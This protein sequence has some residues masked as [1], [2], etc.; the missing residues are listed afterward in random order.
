MLVY[1]SST[2]CLR[3]S[4]CSFKLESSVWWADFISF[5]CFSN[6]SINKS[7]S[8]SF[9]CL[10]KV[11]VEIS[12]VISLI[13]TT[14]SWKSVLSGLIC[15]LTAFS[16]SLYFSTSII[17]VAGYRSNES[18]RFLFSS[19]RTENFLSFSKFWIS[20]FVIWLLKFSI[21]CI[22]LSF[23]SFSSTNACLVTLNFFFKVA[24][25][26]AASSFFATY[27]LSLLSFLSALSFLSFFFDSLVESSDIDTVS[28]I[29]L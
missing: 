15:L 6:P 25:S 24:S 11:G 5:I 27:F 22:S 13:L 12:L 10:G 14:S 29:F 16:K 23:D 3:V 19:I 7:R 18:S 20:I 9:V 17:F 21:S 8:S 2:Y 26:S 28:S 1:R 4:I